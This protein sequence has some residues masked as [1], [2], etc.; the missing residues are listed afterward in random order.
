MSEHLNGQISL[1][2]DLS[3]EE[4]SCPCGGELM[5]RGPVDSVAV[6]QHCG[7]WCQVALV[8]KSDAESGNIYSSDSYFL[9]LTEAA[10]FAGPMK[11][12]WAAELI[13]LTGVPGGSLADFGC[14]AGYLVSAARGMGFAA[15]GF[16]INEE[17]LAAATDRFGNYFYPTDRFRDFGPYDIV[18]MTDV[19]EHLPDPVGVVTS[20]VESLKPGGRLLVAC[21]RADSWS[22]KILGAR[23]GQ[24]KDEHVYYPTKRGLIDL[25]RRSGLEV[26]STGTLYKRL[27]L[28]Y[29]ASYADSYPVVHPW[30]DRRLGRFP[31]RVKRLDVKAPGGEQYAV[32]VRNRS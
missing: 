24:V 26:V 16:D 12:R 11:H 1:D 19:L 2:D 13:S 32:A 7:A 27:N 28:G 29:L 5:S 10:R 8:D 15:V 3:F 18:T 4:Q 31:N 25:L 20:V 22:A 23:W 14:G 6:C 30:V 17:S 21:P 9:P